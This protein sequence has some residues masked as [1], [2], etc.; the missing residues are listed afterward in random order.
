M[1]EHPKVFNSLLGQ[2]MQV[3][4]VMVSVIRRHCTARFWVRLMSSPAINLC[5]TQAKL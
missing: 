3:Q 4:A 5:S 2:R 1:K